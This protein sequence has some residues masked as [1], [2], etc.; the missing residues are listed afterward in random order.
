ML[1][2]SEALCDF[3][4]FEHFDTPLLASLEDHVSVGFCRGPSIR[5]VQHAI[6]GSAVLLCLSLVFLFG[7]VRN[8]HSVCSRGWLQG[9]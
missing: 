5:T 8:G 9:Q 2:I 3:I 1:A 4:V 7:M 6:C